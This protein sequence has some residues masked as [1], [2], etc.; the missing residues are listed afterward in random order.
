MRHLLLQLAFVLFLFSCNVAQE[1][2]K[3]SDKA[4]VK[5]SIPK[6]EEGKEKNDETTENIETP[7]VKETE[8][9]VREEP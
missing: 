9:T 7:E 8:E 2:K 6:K 4:I 5:D 3:E 1:N